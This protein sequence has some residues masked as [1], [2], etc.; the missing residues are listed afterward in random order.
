MDISTQIKNLENARAARAARLE[1]V[2]AKSV[3]EAR[4]MS[5]EE[6][7]EFDELEAE[8]KQIDDDL[9][10]L[11]RLVKMQGQQ[12]AS[13][14][15]AAGGDP[16]GASSSRG[17]DVVPIG[18]RSAH[19]AGPMIMT[20]AKEADEA[21][22]GQ[23]FVRKLIAKANA[24]FYDEDPVQLAQRRWG[25]DNP[26]LVEVIKAGVPGHGS[27]SSEPGG[28]LVSTD[29]RY[30]GD[31]IEFLY[32][33]TVYNQLPLRVVPAHV[34]IKGQDGAATGY[35]VGE[36]RPIPMS[37]ADFSSVSLTPLKVAALS[38]ASK[39]LLR[40]SS[41]AAELFLRDALVEALSQRIDNTFLGTGAAVTA[42]S[43]AGL[44]HNLSATT[45]AGTDTDGVINDI[46]ELRQRFITAKNSGGLYWVMNPSLASSLGLL[47]NALGQREFTQINENGGTLEGNPV[48]VGDNV[49]ENHLILLKPSDIYRIE[50]TPGSLEVSFSEQATIEMADD[51][52]GEI[53]T[54]TAQSNQVVSMYQ[55]DSI[56][57]KAVMP[58]NFQKR[59][60]SAVAYINDADYGGSIST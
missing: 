57:M 37:N 8:I 14:V 17:G 40:D 28:E 24:K 43:P 42:V 27:G 58:M 53:D 31:F 34:T 39:E 47:R 52:T 16:V 51:P 35:W 49:N 19:G 6:A 18:Q 25:R 41:P 30:T 59:R 13:A 21:F 23:M 4:S 44:L 45:S 48:I 12:A 3:E 56:A 54:P 15:P 5:A 36:G 10:R 11:H 60:A 32:S 1:T 55:T 20:H 9:A 38:V 46:K 33:Q 2:V 22:Q 7:D 26:R 29:N 50:P